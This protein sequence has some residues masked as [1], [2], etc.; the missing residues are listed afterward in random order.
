MEKWDGEFEAIY[1]GP[2]CSQLV[3]YSDVGTDLAIGTED[4]LHLNVYTPYKVFFV[5]NIMII[6]NFDVILFNH[7]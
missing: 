3:P 6:M 5:E 7:L 1:D 2:V 4:C